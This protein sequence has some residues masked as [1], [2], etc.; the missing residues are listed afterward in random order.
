MII[1]GSLTEEAVSYMLIH[2]T[3]KD[4]EFFLDAS[5]SAKGTD[6]SHARPEIFVFADI[7]FPNG[8]KA[9]GFGKDT[10]VEIKRHFTYNAVR[11]I[12]QLVNQIGDEGQLVV[13]TES[14]YIDFD[15]IINIKEHKKVKHI[16]YHELLDK[17]NEYKKNVLHEKT[18]KD[19]ESARSKGVDPS[20][21][22]SNLN[23]I[24]D[25]ISADNDR[26]IEKAKAEFSNGNIT[27]LLG[28]G[29]SSSAGLPAWDCLLKA[30]LNDSSQL[31]LDTDDYSAIGAASFHS[32]IIKARYI[33]SSFE[34]D[35][36]K[37]EKI[38]K[39]LQ[40]ALYGKYNQK[41]SELIETIAKLCTQN[42][43]STHIRLVS[44]IITLNYDD[45][46]EQ[47]L[48]KQRKVEYQPIFKDGK[49][50]GT[51]LPIIHVHGIIRQNEIVPEIP[52]LSEDAYHELY[53]RGNNWT[54]VD[55]LHAFYRNTCIFIGL[56][57]SD[58]N[59]R[60]LLEFVHAES[61]SSPK[62]Y[63]ILPIKTLSNHNW[64]SP[65]PHKYY[66]KDINKEAT[67]K[68]RQEDVYRQLGIQ[69]IWYRDGQYDDIPKI[70][71]RIASIQPTT[72]K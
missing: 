20:Y 49:Y 14:E 11:H 24:K 10:Y 62:H 57:M 1:E 70:L 23:H 44:S 12:R 3:G 46:I 47:E 4:E 17:F 35:A 15:S 2:M 45:L 28:A 66:E 19:V 40:E 68:N 51:K 60:R 9:L 32:N 21:Q 31:P 18:I 5:P 54:N 42:N 25:K 13:I 67:F 37:D 41:S 59:L 29:V 64:D 34:N 58:P 26:V 48:E 71:K 72:A 63:A 65:N 8:L 55:L 7:Y 27:L 30:L 50:E 22:T 69:V 39:I 52:V 16:S 36:K 43:P 61:G 53:R 56:S 33:L 38:I 6:S